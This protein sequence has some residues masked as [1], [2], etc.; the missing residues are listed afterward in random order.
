AYVLAAQ[1][2]FEEAEPL[3]A[4]VRAMLKR[5]LGAA[6][7]ELTH[8]I[9][10]LA[11]AY[12]LSG[13]PRKIKELFDVSIAILEHARAQE[14]PGAATALEFYSEMLRVLDLESR[15]APVHG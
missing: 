12:R 6:G 5:A 7:D 14:G 8:R 15:S 1:R 13:R 11:R 3:L 9:D 2:K 10:H 4:D